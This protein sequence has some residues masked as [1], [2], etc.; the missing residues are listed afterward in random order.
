ME[1]LIDDN[2]DALLDDFNIVVE[3]DDAPIKGKMTEVW[4]DFRNK[5]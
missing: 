5:L 3:S 2:D 4:Y 1:T